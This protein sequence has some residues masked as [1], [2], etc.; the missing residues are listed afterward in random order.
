MTQPKDG[1]RCRYRDCKE[2]YLIAADND[3]VTCPTCRKALGLDPL[4]TPAELATHFFATMFGG[5]RPL[6]IPVQPLDEH[7]DPD[8]PSITTF[9]GLAASGCFADP[10]RDGIAEAFDALKKAE[11]AVRERYLAD[12][13]NDAD[14]LRPVLHELIQASH[15]TFK[16]RTAWRPHEYP[17]T[18]DKEKP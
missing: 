14:A 16:A 1:L 5:S 15:H 6:P 4:T 10:V 8:G 12:T 11:D 9:E 3:Q 2:Q 17:R 18:L 13:N 7:G